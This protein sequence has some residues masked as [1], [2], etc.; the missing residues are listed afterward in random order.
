MP[1]KTYS[2]LI[3]LP[4]FAERFRYLQIDGHV[5]NSTFGFDRNFNQH[6]YAS[7]EWKSVRNKVIVRDCACDL[8]VV[9]HEINQRI[10]VHHMNPILL[11]DILHQTDI[12]LNPEFLVCVTHDTHNAI[13]YGDAR[14]LKQTQI[15]ERVKHDTCPWRR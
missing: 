3:L 4:T 10:M 5:G 8:A 14:I 12:L 6:F 7:P 11:Q 1:M 9:G 13:H 15:T 2:E